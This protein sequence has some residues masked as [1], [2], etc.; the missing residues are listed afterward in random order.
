MRDGFIEYAMWFR[1]V[2][3]PAPIASIYSISMEGEFLSRRGDIASILLGPIRL[4][5]IIIAAMYLGKLNCKY[6]SGRGGGDKMVNRQKRVGMPPGSF[7][8]HYGQ[9]LIEFI[10]LMRQ[11][12]CYYR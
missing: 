1:I 7:Y 12:I 2:R 8:L 5:I 11:M 6:L 9:F 3:T 10:G 4:I